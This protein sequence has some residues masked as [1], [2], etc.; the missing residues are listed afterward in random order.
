M[1]R[2]PVSSSNLASVG[3]DAENMVLEVEFHSG[4]IYQYFK[5]PESKYEALMKDDSHGEYFDV[6]IKKGGFRYREI[7]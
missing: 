7:R 1:N 5:V 3:Y 6:H 2:I 4:G